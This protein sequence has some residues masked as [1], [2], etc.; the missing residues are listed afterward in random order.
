MSGVDWARLKAVF[1]AAIDVPA[2]ERPALLDAACEGDP[3]LRAEVEALLADADEADCPIERQTEHM[4]GWLGGPVEPGTRIGAYEIVRELG[5]GGM[6]TVL[7]ARRADGHYS[8]DVALKMIRRMVSAPDLESRFRRERQILASLAHANIARLL[9]GGV[10][11]EGEPFLVMEYVAGEP[12]LAFAARHE[13]DTR[14]RIA[15]FL[16][17][18]RAVAY[19]HSRLV[20]HRDIKPSN[21]L[22]TAE[23]EPKLVDFGLAKIL[24]D[25]LDGRD[26]RTQVALRAF[27][28]SYASPEQ[29]LGHDVSTA[30]DVYSLG[31][32]LYELLTGAPPFDFGSSRITD[33]LRVIETVEPARPSEALKG[34]A[35]LAT[36][37]RPEELAGD[38]DNI[39]LTA[40]RRVPEQRYESVA[41]LA[42]DLERYLDGRPVLARAQTWRYRAGKFVRRHAVGVAASA[43]VSVALVLTLVFALWQAG[44]A[45]AER[46]RAARRFADVRGLA[47][48]LLFDIG[49]RVERLPGATDAREALLGRAV[50]YLDSLAEES[51]DD[52][53][54]A[55]EL[56]SA[57]EKVG[58]LQGNPTNPNL[59]E[60][61]DAIASY[62]KARV[63]RERVRRSRP[64]VMAED[65]ALAENQR[66]LGTILAQA[67]DFP[68]AGGELSAALAS[69]ESFAVSQPNDRALRRAV[70][71][72]RHDVG[73]N[74]TNTKRYAAALEYFAGAIAAA[75][76]LLREQPDDLDTLALL[77]DS[78]AQHGL[79]LSWEGRQ[80]DAEVAMAQAA[81][82]Y[83][84][85]VRAHPDDVPLAAGLWSTYWL[86]SSVYEEQDDAQS[87]RFAMKALD[88]A[89]GALARDPANMRARQQLAKALSR[90]GQTSTNID[91]HDDAMRY[92]LESTS[93]LRAMT[94][95]EV[96]NGRLN[97]ELALALTRLAQARLRQGQADGALADATEA[98]AIYRS[99]TAAAAGDKRS[100]RNLVLTYELIGDVHRTRQRMREAGASYSQG[101]MLLEKLRDENALAAVDVTYLGHLRDKAAAAASTAIAE[102]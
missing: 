100:V 4:R 82:L 11:S 63:L 16:Q 95:R 18:C 80:R 89:R 57:Y 68:A 48:A 72:T 86:T 49:P 3:T 53:T 94:S 60:L 90:A 87:H 45:R 24:D 22:M 29:I 39:V 12:M 74:F 41:A 75:E 93:T 5:R 10:T 78:H 2:A 36:R 40:I 21:I 25:A 33:I 64:G 44:V 13:L 76:A 52:L 92:L 77:A 51:A 15:L 62:R 101:V 37:T 1:H 35:S 7:L 27:T 102:P 97:S 66:V 88:V 46:D 43:L 55:G 65:V 14:A 96:R 73:R 34:T 91:R 38:L 30:T 42:A 31:V 79:A 83:E 84:P 23:R 81:A 26:A 20:V 69:Y 19:A 9:D 59:V 67:N 6:G 70:A 58:D 47:N 50:D 99:V 61:D 32:V 54:L 98:A 56:A 17:V 28:P 85:A 71:R 8:H